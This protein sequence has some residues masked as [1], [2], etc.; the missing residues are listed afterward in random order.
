[1]SPCGTAAFRALDRHV[2][3]W[4]HVQFVLSASRV[5]PIQAFWASVYTCHGFWT[6]RSC[7]DAAR[8][9]AVSSRSCGLGRAQATRTP[10]QRSWSEAFAPQTTTRASS[11]TSFA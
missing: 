6:Y 5:E 11:Q 7:L 4:V 3:D 10:S 1:M 8:T 2:S 9:A